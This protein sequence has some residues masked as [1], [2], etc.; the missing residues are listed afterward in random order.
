M[1]GVVTICGSYK[2]KDKMWEWY[3]T[4]SA[5]GYMVFMPAFDAP[6]T[7]EELHKLHDEKIAMSEFIFV[8]APGEYVG[9]DTQREINYAKSINVEVYYG[10]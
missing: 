10:I 1:K 6:M 5:R 2:F 3:K 7:I 9:E 8:V 4:L